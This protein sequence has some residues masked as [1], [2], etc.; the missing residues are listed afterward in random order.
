[1]IG[2]AK[3]PRTETSG[4]VFL[5]KGSKTLRVLRSSRAWESQD[6]RKGA[7]IYPAWCGLG[8]VDRSGMCVDW[9]SGQDRSARNPF[10][11]RL[12]SQPPHLFAAG[13]GRAGD[14]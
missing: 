7:T 12:E 11:H 14:A 6:E 5:S 13:F 1:M 10:A 3:I 8:R 4:V 2:F 9:T